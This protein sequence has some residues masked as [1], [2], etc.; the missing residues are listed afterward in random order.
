M[1]YSFVHLLLDIVTT[2]RFRLYH[3]PGIP[4]YYIVYAA[5]DSVR[6]CLDKLQYKKSRTDT[7]T[8]QLSSYDIRALVYSYVAQIWEGQLMD[9]SSPDCNNEYESNQRPHPHIHVA[10]GSQGRRGKPHCCNPIIPYSRKFSQVQLFTKT[11]MY[12]YAMALE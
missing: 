5:N 1:Y 12:M 4:S 10:A 2:L 6:H 8:V 9:V 7:P 3:T 11:Y